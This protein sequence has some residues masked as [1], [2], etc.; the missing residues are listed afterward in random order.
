MVAAVVIETEVADELKDDVAEPEIDEMETFAV[1]VD[2]AEP[3]TDELRTVA[4]SVDAILDNRDAVDDERVDKGKN[5]ERVDN[6]LVERLPVSVAAVD[7]AAMV[8]LEADW[9]RTSDVLASHR[10]KRAKLMVFRV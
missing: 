5:I 4:V 1:D 3:D 9:A 6:K 10:A 8:E 7:E 2:A